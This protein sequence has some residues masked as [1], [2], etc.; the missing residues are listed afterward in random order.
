MS[1]PIFPDSHTRL[2][3]LERELKALDRDLYGGDGKKGKLDR[4]QT[5]LES[6]NSRMV[7]LQTTVA[8]IAGG[9]GIG[10]GSVSTMLFKTFFS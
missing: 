2:A 6:I 5:E 3:L 1:D 8:V 4:I 9:G 10:I 7:K